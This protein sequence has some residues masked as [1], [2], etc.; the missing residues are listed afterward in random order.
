MPGMILGVP[1]F[2]VFYAGVKAWAR[3]RLKKKDLP[4]HTS[5]YVNLVKVNDEGEVEEFIPESKKP[6][7]KE[8][9]NSFKVPFFNKLIEKIKEKKKNK[10]K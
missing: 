10:D 8:G 6:F 2:A 3:N 1:I 5:D 9:K 4:H 7:A